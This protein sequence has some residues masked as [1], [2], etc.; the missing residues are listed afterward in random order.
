MLT[1]GARSLLSLGVIAWVLGL[2]ME[3]RAGQSTPVLEPSLALADGP[4]PPVG[5]DVI[6][7]DAEGRATIRAVRLAE[8]LVAD[9]NLAEALYRDVPGMAGFTQVEPRAGEPATA[10][11][12]TWLSF[13]DDN[14]YVS[15][16]CLDTDMERLVATEMRRDSNVMWSGNDIVVFVFDTFYDRRNSILFTVNAAGRPAGR[17]GGQRASVPRRLEPGVDGQDRPLRG[18]LDGRG[19]DAVQVAPL[20]ARPRTGVGLQR[21][22]RE[23]VR[24]TRFRR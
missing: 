14:V 8:P 4:P 3:A 17:A 2:A 15:F 18:R 24:P 1:L 6:A 16:K 21:H 9:G 12:E 7:R 19:R 5:P 10:R 20:P 13:D 23:A 11:T 22:A